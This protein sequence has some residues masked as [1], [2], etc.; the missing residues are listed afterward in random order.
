MIEQIRAELRQVLETDLDALC[1]HTNLYEVGLH[2]IA[3]LR[4]VA[5]LSELAGSRIRYAALARNPTLADWVTLV[6]KKK[7][8]AD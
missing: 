1:E 3:I 6:S 8:S 5:P 4:L 2:S 7:T